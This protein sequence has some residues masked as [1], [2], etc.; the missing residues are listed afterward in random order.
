MHGKGKDALSPRIPRLSDRSLK[1]QVARDCQ[2][3]IAI[4]NVHTAE[5]CQLSNHGN[6]SKSKFSFS[7][8]DRLT[9]HTFISTPL[10]GRTRRLRNASQVARREQN[11][12]PAILLAPQAPDRAATNVQPGPAG[13]APAAAIYIPCT[14]NHRTPPH[15]AHLRPGAARRSPAGEGS[16]T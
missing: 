14:R 15:R 1:I 12:W 5:C 16:G 13:V 9:E 8:R 6:D 4:L 7:D 3:G 10:H 11:L 2:N